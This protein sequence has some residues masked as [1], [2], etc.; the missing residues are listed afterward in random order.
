MQ[1]NSFSQIE[2]EKQRGLILRLLRKEKS[3]LVTIREIIIEGIFNAT[4]KF[5][6]CGNCIAMVVP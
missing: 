1:T 2:K 4:I 5:S 6:D 3:Q